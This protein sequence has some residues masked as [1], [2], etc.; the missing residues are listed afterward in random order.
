MRK[1]NGATFSFLNYHRAETETSEFQ[2][3]RA[4]EEESIPSIDF[5]TPTTPIFAKCA[6]ETQP[7]MPFNADYGLMRR[8]ALTILTASLTAG[9]ITPTTMF[10]LNSSLM[11]LFLPKSAI[12]MLWKKSK[13]TLF[14]SNKAPIFRQSNANTVFPFG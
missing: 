2:E 11:R 5:T 8:R 7:P 14:D 3:K 6:T 12:G 4:I 9:L 13:R 1:P 10:S